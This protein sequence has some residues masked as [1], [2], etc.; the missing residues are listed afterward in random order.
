MSK[1]NNAVRISNNDKTYLILRERQERN[2]GTK[3]IRN[4]KKDKKKYQCRKGRLNN[5]L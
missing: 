4:K 3:V 1:E 5:D 2:M